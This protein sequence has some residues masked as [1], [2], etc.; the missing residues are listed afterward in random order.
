MRIDGTTRESVLHVALNM[1]QSDVDEFLAMSHAHDRRVLAAL[2]IDKYE[3]HADGFCFSSDDGE[4]IGVGAM[5]YA[6][7]NVVTLMFFATEKFA[8]IAN[9]L[10]K[11]TKQRLFPQYRET[12]VHRIECVSMAGYTT[13]HRWIRLVGLQ[14][15]AVMR[16]Y[17]RNGETFHQFAWVKDDVR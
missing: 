11:F 14:E 3:N 7:P 2:L 17:G 8:S 16:G 15:E 4:P 5:V 12:G 13:M 1:R 6:R 10:A 9:P